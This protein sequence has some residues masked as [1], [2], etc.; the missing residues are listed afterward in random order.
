MELET[1][2]ELLGYGYF[3]FTILL[4]FAM[5]GYAYHMYK[6]EKTGRKSY[7]KY[8]DIALKDEIYDVPVE[9]FSK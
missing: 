9:S 1:L 7:E 8:S 2:K 4:V 6:S 5:Y 3:A